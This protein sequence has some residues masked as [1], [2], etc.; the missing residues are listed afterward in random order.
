MEQERLVLVDEE[1]REV[2]IAG[3]LAAHEGGLLHR[4]FSI[5][6]VNG[7]GEL[8]LQRRATSKYHCGGLWSNTCCG[9]PRPREPLVAA[10]RRRLREEMGFDCA[11]THA[12]TVRY[13]LALDGGLVENELDHVF[14]GRWDG[15]PS[16]DPREADAWRW[17][18]REALAAW[19][20]EAPGELTPWFRLIVGALGGSIW[21]PGAA[22]P[23][24]AAA[25]ASRTPP[26]CR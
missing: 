7:A 8:L 5:F 13:R 25:G 9:H 12:S 14:V 24:R 20:A 10:A 19:T 23:L 17:I 26:S 11:L 18:G 3:K 6:V 4:A 21:T 2:G 1:D 22:D 16:P 15:A